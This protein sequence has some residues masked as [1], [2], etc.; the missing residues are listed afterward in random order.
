LLLLNTE[1]TSFYL[2]DWASTKLLLRTKLAAEGPQGVGLPQ[3]A[4]AQSPDSIFLV[5]PDQ[6]KVSLVNGAGQRLRQYQ[7]KGPTSPSGNHFRL[8]LNFKQPPVKVGPHLYLGCWVELPTEDPQFFA[9]G[10]VVM[11]LDLATGQVK[12][13]VPY[14]D[15]YRQPGR[16]YPV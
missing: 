9:Q 2:Y 8:A 4:V 16:R 7:V 12:V 3:M 1:D 5:A 11:H 15:L 10:R 6:G 13:A 14:P